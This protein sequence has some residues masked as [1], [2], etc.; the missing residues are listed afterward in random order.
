MEFPGSNSNRTKKSPSPDQST[1]PGSEASSCSG[2]EHNMSVTEMQFHNQQ[3]C[4]DM[5]TIKSFR[6]RTFFLPEEQQ[7]AAHGNES[8]KVLITLQHECP[9]AKCRKVLDSDRIMSKS[10]REELGFDQTTGTKILGTHEWYCY[11][12]NTTILPMIKIRVGDTNSA[13]KLEE[14]PLFH[15]VCLRNLLETHLCVD[16]NYRSVYQRDVE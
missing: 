3:T 7:A 1:M 5:K 10:R 12:C 6:P 14:V 16:I 11:N 15:P 8:D 2:T 13:R 9:N 4:H